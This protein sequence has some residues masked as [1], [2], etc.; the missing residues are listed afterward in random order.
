MKKNS[1]KRKRKMNPYLKIF[2]KVFSITVASGLLLSILVMVGAI[3]GFFGEMDSL[4]LKAI[5]SNS[6]SQIIY[7]D[8]QGN[9]Q[10]LT[11]LS[12]EQNRVWVGLADIPQDMKDA[13]IAIEDERFYSHHGVDIK[14]TTKAFF[15]FIGNKLT[16]KSS[17]FGGS[18]ITQQLVK[19]ITGD[20]D[21]TAA[22]KIQEMSRAV[23]LEK[24]LSKDEILELYLNSIYLSQ[25]CNGVQAAS[26][27]FFGKSVSELN[28]A[29]CA[30]I[31]GITQF[32]SRYDPLVNPQNN[33]EKQEVVLAK[34]LELGYITQEEHDS[35]VAY[36][37]VFTEVDPA[38]L[39]TGTINSYFTDQVVCDILEDL[40]GLGYSDIIAQKM[41]YSGGLKIVVTLDPNV[42]SAMENVFENTDNFP[43]YNPDN[44]IQAAMVVLDPYT[45]AV[46]GV[47]GGVG[48][49]SGNL[50]LNRA[51]QT[52]RQPGSSI[53]P[54][55]VYGPAIENGV[56]TPA[57]IYKDEEIT[58]IDGNGK[59]WTPRNYDN[60]YSN[61]GVSGQSGVGK[62]IYLYDKESWH[63]IA[64]KS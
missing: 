1:R 34:M 33:K 4:D 42:Q 16:G 37:L 23:N 51:S 11:T 40:K 46:K 12:A 55:A 3:L 29:E 5:T 13:F 49:K 48:K 38:T 10:H 7:I 14:R 6:S 53:K 58:F 26:Q 25:G 31:A 21:V 43:N 61:E 56:I 15:S 64:C 50:V 28:L 57:D 18:T 45:G 24:Q 30:S 44:P 20:D 59:P 17:S 60:T 63:Y 36:Q 54:I 41:L 2:L 19:N 22:R 35:A 52:L 27:K 32:P 39:S 47:V 9:E 8:S 62:F